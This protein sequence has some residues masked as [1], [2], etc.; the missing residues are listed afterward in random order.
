MQNN[1]NDAHVDVQRI[2]IT[3][4]GIDLKEIAKAYGKIPG[5]RTLLDELQ[6]I[7]RQVFF[8][9]LNKLSVESYIEI[10]QFVLNLSKE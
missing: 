1:T 4:F 9:P 8:N 2:L 7:G 5:R 3:H 6:K 10:V